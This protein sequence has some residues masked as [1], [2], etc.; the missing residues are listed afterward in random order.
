MKAKSVTLY[1][2]GLSWIDVGIECCTGSTQS[3]MLSQQDFSVRTAEHCYETVQPKTH[4]YSAECTPTS[5]NARLKAGECSSERKDQEVFTALSLLGD[6]KGESVSL[7]VGRNAHDYLEDCFNAEASVLDRDKFNAI[8]E[9]SK[10]DLTI[11]VGDLTGIL[12][13][14]H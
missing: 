1:R 11:L 10:S 14:I 7:K 6:S 4:R 2:S 3:S 9:L 5:Q 13:Y 8:P 12:R